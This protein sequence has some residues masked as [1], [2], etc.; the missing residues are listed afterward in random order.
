[1]AEVKSDALAGRRS[2]FLA[3]ATL[4]ANAYLF[5][6]GLDGGISTLD[7][8]LKG[9]WQIG[10]L[11]AIRE[12]VAI[13][14]LFA[15]VPMLLLLVFVPHLP[16]RVFLPPLVFV[17]WAGLGAP[18]FAFR[19]GTPLASFLL[20][21]SQLAVF[22]FATALVKRRTGRWH[23]AVSD[24]PVKTH[25]LRRVLL[26]VV[27]T[28]AIVLV[29]LPLLGAALLAAT[30]ERQTDGY[31]RFTARGI[32]A[33]ETVL[34]KEGRTVRLVGMIHIGERAFY[35]NLFAGIPPRAL[36]LVEG[37]SDEQGRLKG[38]F[39]YRRLARALGL[40]E[41]V[42]VQS[43]WMSGGAAGQAVQAGQAGKMASAAAAPVP[44]GGQRPVIMRADV[45]VSDLSDPTISFLREVG[46][47]YGSHSLLEAFRRLDAMSKRFS[48]KD[49]STVYADLIDR[50]NAALIAVFD[51]EAQGHDVIVI[52]WGAEHMPGIEKALRER[53]YEVRSR[54]VLDA[55]RYASLF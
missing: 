45:D 29:A 51:R 32:E 12:A 53:G 2:Q 34:E 22:L 26:A 18:P 33:G 40:E 6:F 25:L 15:A 17:L 14:V 10:A 9:L 1:M 49:L 54:R 30:V 43:A 46:A 36:V 39:S 47:I 3:I 37:V 55:V 11:S 8:A 19:Q 20:C 27:A 31:I 41:Q 42:E 44:S 16:K 28:L 4:L 13:A 52:P 48:E 23:L 5:A 50:R 24:L 38:E 35:E 7:E 21:A